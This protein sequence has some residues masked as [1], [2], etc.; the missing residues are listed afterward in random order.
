MAYLTAG[1]ITTIVNLLKASL[2][3]SSMTTVL[4]EVAAAIA[5]DSGAVA[6]V[7]AVFGVTEASKLLAV[8]ADKHI[9]TFAITEGGLKIGA[10]AGT[11]MTA[12]AAE[13]NVND[14]VTAGVALASKTAVLGTDKNLDELHLAKLFLGAGAGVE[15]TSTPAQLNSIPA[16]KGRK[17]T[18]QLRVAAAV[19]DTE[20]VTIGADVYEVDTRDVSHVTAGRIRLNLS[21]GSTVK[22]QG[23]LT[24]AEPVT[25]GDTIVIGTKT[26]TFVPKNTA[27]TDGE[28]DMGDSEAHTKLNI[29]IALKGGATWTAGGANANPASTFVTCGAAFGGDALVLTAIVGGTP[30]NAIATTE[31]LTH[32][33][34]IFDGVV[35]GTTTPGVDPT[36][37]EFTTAL[38]AAINGSGTEPVS[39]IRPAAGTI[40]VYK[41]TIGVDTTA[42]TETLSGVNNVWDAATLHDGAAASSLSL[43]AIARVPNAVEVATDYLFVPLDFQPTAVVI[44]VRTTATGAKVVWGGGCTISAAGLLIDNLA[45]T[46]W[47]VAETLYI[48][49]WA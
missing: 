14:G 20:T 34:N 3:K 19:I 7:P 49:A 2:F 25:A 38:L 43:A 40:V 18:G 47:S 16:S 21:A 42:T 4:T 33:S 31:G 32:I 35:L 26:Y 8:G 12:S 22:A 10:G 5:A 1:K 27:T 44:D 45:G 39:A 24:I 28:I 46:D 6:S 15:L 36:A 9:D 23:T 17:A 13:L 30:G 11:A 41:D 37:A 29:V 48:L